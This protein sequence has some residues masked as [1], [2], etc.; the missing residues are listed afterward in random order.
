MS[1]LDFGDLDLIFKVTGG[2]TWQF[3]VPT[4]SPEPMDGISPNFRGYMI[5]TSLRAEQNFGDLDLIFKVTGGFR[6]VKIS[7]KLMYLFSLWLDFHFTFIDIPMGQSQE[8]T[9]F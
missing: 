5:W 6:Y 4:I 2:L 1:C 3:L 9:V 8:C 7:L